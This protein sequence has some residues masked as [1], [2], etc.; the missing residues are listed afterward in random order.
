[1]IKLSVLSF[2]SMA[3]KGGGLKDDRQT[4]RVE[5]LGLSEDRFFPDQMPES[6]GLASI[7]TISF[8]ITKRRRKK[9]GKGKEG[10]SV[11]QPS[12]TTSSDGDD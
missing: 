1:M 6:R 4:E 3:R 9:E 5:D 11:D 2:W 7:T 12:G 8:E 10:K